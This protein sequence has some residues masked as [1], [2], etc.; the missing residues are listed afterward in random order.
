VRQV[1]FYVLA[2]GGPDARLRHACRLADEAVG[3]GMHVYLLTSG[4]SEA[5]RLDDLLWMFNDRSFLPHEIHS[6]Q[7][8]SH[9]RVRIMLGDSAAP[10]THRQLLINLTDAVPPQLESYERIAEIVEIDPEKKRA[11]R[12]RYKEYRERGCTLE[13][14]NVG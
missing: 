7:A 9:P 12:E 13:S 3:A 10:P 2:E 1:D 14:H 5:Q 8:A 4:A 6:G 11:A